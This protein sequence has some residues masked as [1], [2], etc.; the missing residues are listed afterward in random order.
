MS[1]FFKKTFSRN[2]TKALLIWSVVV[3]PL[4]TVAWSV[5]DGRLNLGPVLFVGGIWVLYII[6]A[7]IAYK[8]KWK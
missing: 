2:N 7:W 8:R 3:C 1:T 4:F 5:Q 6:V